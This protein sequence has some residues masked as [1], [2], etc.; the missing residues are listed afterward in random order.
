MEQARFW[1]GRAAEQ[2]DVQAQF[3]LG[4]MHYMGQ[5]GPASSE[6][7][8]FWLKRAAAQGHD[9]AVLAV[10]DMESTCFLCGKRHASGELNMKK[11][12][13]CKCAIYC[14]R[15]CRVSHWKKDGGHKTMCKKIRALNLKMAGSASGSSE[16]AGGGA[17]ES[18][19][20]VGDGG[21]VG[22]EASAKKKKPKKK[23]KKKKKGK[24]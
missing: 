11:C 14:S 18:K 2:G 24:R 23:K 8:I 15:K 7:A 3:G 16:S 17:G 19:T 13:V 5:G 21:A 9:I 22:A 10:Q 20:N 1:Y 4:Q 6:H 12:M